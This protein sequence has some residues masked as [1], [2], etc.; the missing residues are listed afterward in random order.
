MPVVV[1]CPHCGLQ[2][3][4]KEE[5]IGRSVRCRG[6]GQMVLISGQP[7][8]QHPAAPA[9]QPVLRA[10]PVSRGLQQPPPAAPMARPAGQLQAAR[11][12]PPAR[13]PGSAPP[14]AARPVQ[15]A[16]PAQPA[17][18]PLGGELLDL[19]GGDFGAA[20]GGLG[21][22]SGSALGDPLGPPPA[23]RRKKS[24]DKNLS[25]TLI[26]GGGVLMVLFCGGVAMLVGPSAIRTAR[27]AV[28]EA[29]VRDL[30]RRIE[31]QSLAR[32]SRSR[33][34]SF[35]RPTRQSSFPARSN[36][37]SPAWLPN[38][39]YAAQLPTRVSFDRYSMQ[40]PQGFTFRPSNRICRGW[41]R[42]ASA[43][44]L[45]VGQARPRS[46]GRAA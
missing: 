1:E 45:T 28:A 24:L 38:P 22:T 6:C 33:G 36:T 37:S 15:P 27:R 20:A 3:G 19:L 12:P 4:A 23:R 31:R 41:R 42:R 10:R 26:F 44:K 2:S 16:A 35:P 25:I 17:P 13:A 34:S 18:Q 7:P 43:N 39:Q 11:R 30:A 21:P 9:P 32:N 14:P 5:W 29:Q 40:A 8:P 46:R